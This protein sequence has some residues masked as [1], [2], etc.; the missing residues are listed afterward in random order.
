MDST[1]EKKYKAT[2]KAAR[3]MI[4][5]LTGEVAELKRTLAAPGASVAI[6][7]MAGEFPGEADSSEAFKRLLI[8]GVDTTTEIPSSR[9]DNKQFYSPH[10][11]ENGKYYCQYGSFLKRDPFLF[12]N[13]F[14]GI[15]PAE[16][17]MMDPQQRMLLKQ[18]W[19]ALEDAG[20]PPSDL[21][22]TD[23]GV[24]L[25]ISSFDHLVSYSAPDIEICSDPYSLTGAS[26]NS[27]AGRLSYYYDIH[28]PCVAVDTA[29]SSSLIALL[30][31]VDALRKGECP[32]AIAGGVNLMISP[33]SFI[34]LCAIR[35]LSVDGRCRAFGDGATG[36]GRGEGCGMVV[37]KRLENAL[38][39]GDRIHAIILGGASGHD[40]QSAGFTAPS[41]V[42]QRRIIEYALKNAG[43]KADDV[44]YVE[45]HG[46]GTELGD[47]IEA[48][49]LAE[50]YKRKNV[51]LLIGSVKS[52]IGHLEAAAGIAALFKTIFAVRDGEIP[53]SINAETLSSHIDWDNTSIKVCRECTVW[54]ETYNQRIAGVS[55]FG[56][57]GT[58]VHILLA[59]PPKEANTYEEIYDETGM[60]DWHV[61]PISAKNDESLR[62]L[63][64]SYSDML[65]QDN[66]NFRQMCNKAGQ[67]RDFFP[68]R[69][70]VSAP[71]ASDAGKSIEDYI[72]GKRN[73]AVTSGIAKNRVKIAFLFSGQGSQIP[74]MGRELYNTHPRFRE[75]MDFC[76]KIAATALDRPLC[77]VMFGDNNELLN[78]TLFTQ[79]AIYAMEAALVEMWRSFGVRPS[80]VLGHSIGE[81]AAA[82][83]SGIFSLDEGMEIVLERACL[84]DSINTPGMMA[85]V[86]TDQNSIKP[87]ISGTGVDIAAINGEDNLVISGPRDTV[88]D[89]LAGMRKAGIEY[90]EMPVSHS[91]H[92]PL[93]EPVLKGYENFLQGRQ[94]NK[95]RT[96]FI[97]SMNVS[98]LNDTTSWPQYWSQQMRRTVRF[99]EAL[100]AIDDV[101]V[102]LEIGASPTLTS[103][104]RNLNEN[105]EWLFSQ[106][107]SIPAWK[108]VS[109]TLARLYVL[110]CPVNFG[111]GIY[112]R[113]SGIDIPL[114][115]FKE[116]L[117]RLSPPKQK[118]QKDAVDMPD[119]E[120]IGEIGEKTMGR[121]M[122][123]QVASMKRLFDRQLETLSKL[124]TAEPEN[125][126]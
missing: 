94:F 70:A 33:L 119:M 104:C 87:F 109:V 96:R 9:W 93:I 46:T 14:F 114:Y 88:K 107:P 82:Y 75:T 5:K 110:G 105:A 65:T 117:H 116:T 79:P 48:G 56:I 68:H 55:S 92:S 72:D 69:L 45:T 123:M 122:K 31:A 78:R 57:S 27:A 102:Y 99:T 51:K 74:G 2:L 1:Q 8:N 85:A 124:S 22:G 62:M 103:L 26:F 49:V 17:D 16:A 41:G 47:P 71:N 52:N 111:G 106:G 19:H 18:S 76:Q 42:A 121:V 61:L 66:C 91:F 77:E 24:F 39:D 58:G 44:A 97:S 126:E 11:G 28:G 10:P 98:D 90:R 125:N 60:P 15:S 25:G 80:I 120:T 53:P 81:Y 12:D 7:G 84:A 43:V 36:F 21:Q 37:L 40:G 38:A 34:A 67:G 35:A 89:I 64:L 115:P 83:A 4:S 118:I 6:I 23:T 30:M 20:I 32:V 108:Q 13:T 101:D 29:C 100:A 73:R 54:P 86:L 63:A 112:G 59:E 95:P 50:V 3:D 113:S